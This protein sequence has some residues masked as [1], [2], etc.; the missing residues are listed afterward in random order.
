MSQKLLV[1]PCALSDA[2][3]PSY[4][5]DGSPWLA[6]RGLRQQACLQCTQD[7]PACHTAAVLV[8]GLRLSAHGSLVA[9]NTALTPGA[10]TAGGLRLARQLQI[11]GDGCPEHMLEGW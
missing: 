11:T 8:L 4:Q 3:I 6:P 9:P 5:P 2:F 1:C 10:G 7:R